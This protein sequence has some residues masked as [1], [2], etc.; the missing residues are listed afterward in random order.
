MS[1]NSNNQVIKMLRSLSRRN[2][3]RKQ[4]E[5]VIADSCATIGDL[6]PIL[7]A[8]G[9]KSVLRKREHI[10]ACWLICN[11]NWT[12]TQRIAMSENLSRLLE[13]A[14][15]AR[16]PV[17]V[18][19]R[20][21]ARGVFVYA[22]S[23]GVLYSGILYLAGLDGLWLCIAALY[24]FAPVCWFI[25]TSGYRLSRVRW[26]I[27]AMGDLAQ[28]EVIGP[29]A[30]AQ[31]FDPL[32]DA[33]AAALKEITA[34]LRPEHYGALSFQTVP[35]LCRALEFANRDI[36]LVILKALT[37][38]GDGRAIKAVERLAQNP[39]TAEISNAAEQLLPIL[40]QRELES[41]SSSQ[42]LRASTAS[43]DGKQELLRGVVAIREDDP[44][45]LVRATVGTSEES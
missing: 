15:N 7:R 30:I 9:S 19:L 32:R 29:I 10:V 5:L 1:S 25:W 33:A 39:R 31:M 44:A 14:T 24:I 38:I 20:W 11:V 26:I 21:F 37:L 42:L 3:L 6:Q 17:R 34:N 40:R 13:S 36:A 35:A 28:P 8:F 12:E 18:A 41:K 43:V 2:P 23:V 4:A 45:V 22:W 27:E 16:K